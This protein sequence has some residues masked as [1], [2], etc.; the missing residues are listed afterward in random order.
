MEIAEIMERTR[1]PLLAVVERPGHGTP[2]L[3]GV[4]TAVRLLNWLLQ[5]A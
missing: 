5:A 1:S 3:L 4:I 2:R